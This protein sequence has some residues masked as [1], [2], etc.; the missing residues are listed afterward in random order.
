MEII[1]TTTDSQFDE[2]KSLILKR[3]DLKKKAFQ[4]QEDYYREFGDLL[5]ESFALKVECI[6]LKKKRLN[7]PKVGSMYK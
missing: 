5:K 7:S 4:Y 1:T 2:Y 3:D 6:T